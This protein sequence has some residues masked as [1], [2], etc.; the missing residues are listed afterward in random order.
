MGDIQ[1][2]ET[3]IMSMDE[4]KIGLLDKDSVPGL[5]FRA[6]ENGFYNIGIQIND[7]EVVKVG[8]ATEDNAME[9]IQYWSEKIDDIKQRY[10]NRIPQLKPFGGNNSYE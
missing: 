1:S 9:K 3:P 6:D 4:F 2:Y 8:S 7:T 5:L 10:K